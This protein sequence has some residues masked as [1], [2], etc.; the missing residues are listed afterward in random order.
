MLINYGKAALTFQLF[1]AAIILSSATTSKTSSNW[2]I[3]NLTCNSIA[4]RQNFILIKAG[5]A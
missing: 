2:M 3:L 4:I 5:P 1:I